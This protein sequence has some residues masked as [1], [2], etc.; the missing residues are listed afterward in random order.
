MIHVLNNL[1]KKYDVILNRLENC[2]T[3]TGDDTL[4]IDLFREKLSDRYKKL[5]VKKKKKLKKTMGAYNM[6]CKQ[7]CQKCGEYGHKP[8]NRRCPEN[9]NKKDKNNKNSERY[10]YKNKKFEGVCYHCSQKG[11]VSKDCWV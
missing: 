2:L 6:Q 5:K 4:T 1:P 3:V 7:R 10:E 9:K 11:H 8:G